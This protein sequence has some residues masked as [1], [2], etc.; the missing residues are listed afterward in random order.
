M[1]RT[2]SRLEKALALLVGLD[3]ARPG[4]NRAAAKAA[5]GALARGGRVLVPAA[6]RTTTSLAAAN[7]ALT[8]ALLGGAALG[9]PQGQELL[10]MAE[11]RGRQDRLAVDRAIQDALYGT[12]ETVKR[13]AAK[14]KS[15]FNTAVSKG[16]KAVKASTAFGKKG[17][18]NNAKKAFSTVTKAASA[19]SKGQKA[20]KSLAGK[21]AYKAAKTVYTDEILRRKMK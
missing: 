8:G 3:I 17:V 12:A 21:V 13:G 11:E 4:T 1:A 7:P 20:P 6:A 5:V 16:L 18:I 9:T 15:K 2:F 14:K 19:R 10:D